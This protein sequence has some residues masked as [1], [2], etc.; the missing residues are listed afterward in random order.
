MDLGMLLGAIIVLAIIGVALHLL[1]TYVP[2]AQPI[3]TLIIVL[4]VLVI[5][6]WLLSIVGIVPR[7]R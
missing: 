2:M 7:F 5:C 4:V 6:L 1:I 3:K